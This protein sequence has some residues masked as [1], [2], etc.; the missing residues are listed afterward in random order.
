MIWRVWGCWM[1][2]PSHLLILTY[3]LWLAA[4]R[5]LTVQCCPVVDLARLPCGASRGLLKADRRDHL[6][7]P[8]LFPR[9]RYHTVYIHTYITSLQLI[10]IIIIHH[11]HTIKTQLST[12][13]IG[14]LASP[15]PR[16]ISLGFLSYLAHPSLLA[17]VIANRVSHSSIH[18]SSSLPVLPNIQL[19]AHQQPTLR[20]PSSSLSHHRRSPIVY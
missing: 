1:D 13:L 19:P 6:Q 17:F 7:Y 3:L 10:I 16:E 2:L 15:S 8:A 12:T 14:T 18:P 11:Q 9:V 20:R 5:T 4:A